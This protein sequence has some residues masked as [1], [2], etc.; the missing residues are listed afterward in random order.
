MDF[1]YRMH[2][3]DFDPMD[4]EQIQKNWSWVKKAIRLSSNSLYQEIK[5]K[6]F[7]SLP[8]FTKAKIH[9][10]L[11]RGRYRT[12]PF[13]LWAGVGLGKWE[14]TTHIELPLTYRPIK[15]ACK[16]FLEKQIEESIKYK[17]APGLKAYKNQVQYWSYCREDEGWRISYLDKN[18]LVVILLEFFEKSDSM[19]FNIF[20]SFF[21]TKNRKEVRNVW[22]MLIKSGIIIPEKFDEDTTHSEIGLDI[23]IKSN[24]ILCRQIHE[25]LER[26]ITEIGNLFVPVE[27]EYLGNFKTW[28]SHTFDDRFVPMSLLA[29]QKDFFSPLETFHY[30][31]K[32]SLN[33][34]SEIL[35]ALWKNCEEFD[36]SSCF[37]IGRTELHHLQIAYKVF[38]ESELVIENMVCNRPFA[39]SGRFSMDPEIKNV[40]AD[41]VERLSS[42][43]VFVDVVLVESIKSNYISRHDNVF[44]SSIYP[45]GN[46]TH[47]THLGINDLYLGIRKDRIILYSKKLKKQVIPAIQHPLNPNQITHALSRLFWEIGNQDQHRFLPYHDPTFQNSNYVPRLTWKGIILQGRKWIINCKDHSNKRALKQFLH[48]SKFPSPFLAGHLDR[49]LLLDWMKPLEL[50]FLWEELQRLQEIT[51][52]ECLWKDQSPF[53]NQTGQQL[54]PQIIY[55]WKSKE[56]Q[57]PTIDFLNPIYKC[58]SQWIYVRI[59]IKE[60]GLMPFLLKPLPSIIT[61]IK[62]KFAIKKWYFLF[63]DS[64]KSEIRLRLLGENQQ[65][66]Q[67]IATELSNYLPES[68]WVDSVKF[69]PYYPEFEKYE[70]QDEGISNSESIFHMESELILFGDRNG[71]LS[72][73]LTWGDI[74]R[75]TW[76]VDL[77]FRL[78]EMSG[79]QNLF[80][81][82]YQRLLK[83][84]PGRER[85]ELNK[86]EISLSKAL[87]AVPGIEFFNSE[88]IKLVSAPEEVLL[89]LIPNHLHMC[90]NRVFPIETP[91]QERRIIYGIYRRLGKSLY[92]RLTNL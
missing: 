40:V 91:M 13:G 69:T 87:N 62:E 29:H 34:R 37:E 2:L 53:K 84:I 16:T 33:P 78:I 57:I 17:S 75:R 38:G 21:K 3:V 18:P 72:P 73:I 30:G 66:N 60:G 7:D 58:D 85:K 52:F 51:V 42:E 76:I 50:D 19:D 27:S 22:E 65:Q 71:D 25:K 54:Y 20:Q 88:F 14:K 80:F 61:G 43:A 45:F 31:N 9:K 77:Y 83:Q 23:K 82:Y 92:G 6:D 39:Y 64:P 47:E 81:H 32:N 4:G 36:L 68:G 11:L 86:S 63:Y 59:G 49:E 56:R 10:Y 8:S 90:C 46:G 79:R 44:E 89:K 24:I 15:S 70:T 55:S 1:I 48:T 28:F 12:T 26:L 41:K 74:Q 67:I 5:N 35:K